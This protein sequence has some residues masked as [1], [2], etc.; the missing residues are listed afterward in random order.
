MLSA[1]DGACL[2]LQG[3]TRS[4]PLRTAAR[5]VLGAAIDA[6]L[7][8]S[9]SL[10]EPLPIDAWCCHCWFAMM[11]IIA[12]FSRVSQRE[13]VRITQSIHE[14]DHHVHTGFWFV[15]MCDQEEV[16]L[17]YGTCRDALSLRSEIQVGFCNT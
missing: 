8:L 10:P 6:G 4:A 2:R 1:R 11:R 13:H 5:L 14:T 16:E 9:M 15:F 7:L 12:C 17:A 3:P